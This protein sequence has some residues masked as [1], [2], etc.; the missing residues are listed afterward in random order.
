MLAGP[1]GEMRQIVGEFRLKNLS[2]VHGGKIIVETNEKGVP[3]ERSGSI[4]SSYLSDVAENS[5]FAPLNIPRWDNELFVQRKNNMIKD[6][7]V[8]HHIYLFLMYHHIHLFL[9]YHHIHFY[10]HFT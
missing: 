6:V 8:H 10:C 1:N 7:E 4:L 9:M 3:N 2:Q 5:T